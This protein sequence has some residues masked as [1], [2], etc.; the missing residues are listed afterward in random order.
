MIKASH[1]KLIKLVDMLNDGALHNGNDLG[2]A[3]KI[4]RSAVWKMIQKLRQYG[5]TVE[6]HGKGYALLEPLYLFDPNKIKK[7]LIQNNMMLHTFESLDSTND[8]FKSIK[9]KNTN[10]F[11]FAEH[12]SKAKGRL[13]RA[14][15][16]PFGQNIYM[17]LLYTFEKDISKL[18]GLSLAVGLAVS[19]V[20]KNYEI[21]V[22]VKWPNDVFSDQK[23]ISGNLIEVIAETHGKCHAVIGIGLNVNMKHNQHPI[24]KNWTSMKEILGRPI[25]RN[26]LTADLINHLLNY[27]EHFDKK[28]FC[29]FK[30]EWAASSYLQDQIISLIAHSETTRGKVI[31]IDDQGCLQLQL[32]DGSTKSFSSGDAN[33]LKNTML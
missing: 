19:A 17:T 12:Q 18:A 27:L 33:I 9:N 10:Q 5:I 31:G 29:A 24:A 2:E 13:G 16:S 3:L 22:K 21:Q 26:E 1:K 32:Q 30:E 8:Y 25:N 28:G 4:T 23:K 20:L 6:A 11:C 15:Y 7:K 14:W